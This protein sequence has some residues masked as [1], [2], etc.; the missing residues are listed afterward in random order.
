M[1]FIKIKILC[2]SYVINKNVKVSASSVSIRDLYLEYVKNSYNSEQ[3]DK[4]NF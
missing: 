3:K 1:G 2:V 4:N